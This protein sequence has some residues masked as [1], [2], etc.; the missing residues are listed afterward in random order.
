VIDR[1][2]LETMVAVVDAGTFDLAAR[3][4]RVT[5]SAISQR[6]KALETEQGRVLLERTK[7]IRPTADGEVLLRLGRQIALLEEEAAHELGAAAGTTSL[8]LAVNA[9][10]LATWLLPAL[11]RA[12]AGR[13]IVVEVLREDQERTAELLASGRVMAAVTSDARAV[14]GCTVSPLGRMRYRAMA[15]PGFVA[16]HL[17]DGTTRAGLAAAPLV[18]FDR[19]D[20]L[21]SRWLRAVTRAPIE[22][23]RH[24]ISGSA[25]F[26]RAIDLGMGWGM[27]TDAQAQPA[28]AA[29]T[30]VELDPRHVVDVPLYWQQWN[31]RAAALD[32]LAAEVVRAAREALVQRG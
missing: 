18:D 6:V 4:L 23:P 2:G 15:T 16:R 20:D 5:P 14:P 10:S 7:P 26:A 29:G 19:D 8:P 24:R 31:L 25:E 11:A 1:R 12:T 28:L 22:P 21:Q 3:R 27:L 9:D 30:L 32:D 17:P 13:P